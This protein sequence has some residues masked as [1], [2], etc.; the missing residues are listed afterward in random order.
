M[1]R[2]DQRGSTFFL[3]KAPWSADARHYPCRRKCQ[4]LEYGILKCFGI[5]TVYQSRNIHPLSSV[6]SPANS[7]LGACRGPELIF[8]G[9]VWFLVLNFTS[10]CKEMENSC[11]CRGICLCHFLSS[12]DPRLSLPSLFSRLPLFLTPTPPPSVSLFLILSPRRLHKASKNGWR[13]R[14]T[15]LR[16]DS[17]KK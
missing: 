11:Q 15:H 4:S 10:V 14:R 6:H 7:C 12:P 1:C 5:D 3:S 9:F 2:D 16:A 8:Q 17:I 13:C